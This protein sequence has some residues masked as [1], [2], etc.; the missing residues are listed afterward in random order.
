MLKN[1]GKGRQNLLN[2]VK[3]DDGRGEFIQTMY[4]I[5]EV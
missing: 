1:I 3:N 2:P 4:P 5:F